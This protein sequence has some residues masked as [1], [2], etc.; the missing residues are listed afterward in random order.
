LIVRRSAL[1]EGNAAKCLAVY[2]IGFTSPAL[3]DSRFYLIDHKSGHSIEEFP[4]DLLGLCGKRSF[5]QSPG[6][7]VHPSVADSLID[8]EP[9]MPRP[10]PRVASLFDV[11]LG[12]SEATDQKIPEALLGTWEIPRRVHGPQKVI[13]RDPP[14]EG[15]DQAGE[16][17]RANHGI[18]FEFLHVLGS[19]CL[20]GRSLGTA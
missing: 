1:E 15:G 10:E 20:P 18:N 16:T 13:L 5:P 3:A 8:R 7:Q 9:R 4:K 6:H 2:A 17:F 12:P 14:I 19:P 11:G